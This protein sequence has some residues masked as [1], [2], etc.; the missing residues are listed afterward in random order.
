MKKCYKTYKLKEQGKQMKKI[1]RFGILG[2]EGIRGKVLNLIVFAI[3]TMTA[4]F[5]ILSTVRSNILTNL[6]AQSSEKQRESIT[7]TTSVVMDAVV[8]LTLE[9]SNRTEAKIADQMF[10][11]VSERVTFLADCV[12]DLLAHPEK[13]GAMPYAGPDPEKDG[14]WS[15][16]VIYADGT[17]P[18]DSAIRTK[19]GLLSN[20]SDM[21]IDLCKS[22]NAST[23]Y[24]ALPEGV[25]ISV[26]KESAG[27]LVD[28]KVR[29]Y[30]PRTRGWY[31]KAVETGELIFTD[32]ERDAVTDVYCIECAKPIYDS[33]GNLLAV[34]GTDLFLDEM[35]RVMQETSIEGE[36]NLLVNQSGHA[37]LEPQ[38]ESFPMAETDRGSD[39]RDSKIEIIS[40]L[41]S[42]ALNGNASGVKLGDLNDGAYYITAS[43]IE[44][45]GWVLISAYN[46]EVTG[47]PAVL[48]QDSLD[49]IQEETVG[50]YHDMKDRSRYIAI[51]ILLVLVAI[52]LAGALLIST[53]IVG[54]LNTI[55]KRIS[56]INEENMIFRMEDTYRT[57][58][59]VEKLAESFAEISEKTVR[60]MDEVLK[61]T[62][63]KERIGAE[64][65]LA[66]DIQSNMLPH[67]FPAFPNRNEFDIY[68]SMD[69]AKEVGGDF[70]DY[71]LIDDDHLCMV[72][73][74][75]SG[76][77][78]PAALFMMASKII[79]QSVAM[80]GNSPAEILN[81]TN[82]AICSNN[83]A[84]MFVTVWLGILE[85][86]TGKM[87][88]ANAGHEYP[89]IKERNGSF[90]IYKDIHGLVLGGIDGTTYQEYEMTLKPGTKLFLYTDGVPEASNS[91]QKLFGMD[92]MVD[93]LNEETDAAPQQILKNVRKAV[94]AFVEEA[95][96]FDDLTMLCLE[97]RGSSTENKE[98]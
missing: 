59:E 23:I 35:Q 29:S 20:L 33:D 43:P 4:A 66:T 28:G 38:E 51:G 52:I 24:I 58:D 13:Y 46:K 40:S 18:S 48:L 98:A 42:D 5:L 7:E 73:A 1:K 74:D 81:K 53:R 76:K 90:E 62:A 85:L 9:R 67:I 49:Q 41:V 88:A 37:V 26:S 80:L 16:K 86:S 69:P 93:A 61:V 27:W 25:H 3:I 97:Y 75:V 56:E 60:Y 19:L 2:L 14:V 71:F 17:D 72:M 45:T 6:V 12:S 82:E 11:A 21:M 68:A 95:E 87:I 77:G 47:Q 70:Y 54:P 57:G 84:E 8:E 34:I 55:T 10:D 36:Y 83:E 64:L 94:D 65:S 79:I 30:D 91:K 50:L 15:A 92:R 22:H 78:V 44:T 89:I 96:Q 31:Q 39:L 32:G 63:E